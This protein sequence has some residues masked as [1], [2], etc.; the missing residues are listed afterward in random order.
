[1]KRPQWW[2][3]LVLV[4]VVG[5]IYAILAPVFRSAKGKPTIS[6]CLSNMKQQ[7]TAM[8]MYAQDYDERFPA[9]PDKWIDAVYSYVKQEHVFKCPSLRETEFGYAF[10][11]RLAG[12]PS[13]NLTNAATVEMIFESVDRRK[14]ATGNKAKFSTRH[15]GLGN[16]AFA[17]GHGKALRR[18]SLDALPGPVWQENAVTDAKGSAKEPKL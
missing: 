18:E 15:D 9:E 1:M 7:G 17:D 4:S 3:W 16:I 8:M 6:S 12:K 2:E 11:T 5:T 13:E 10:Y 14:N